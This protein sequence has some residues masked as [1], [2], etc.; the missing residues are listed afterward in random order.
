MPQRTPRRLEERN[1]GEPEG[2]TLQWHTNGLR[3]TRRFVGQ[4]EMLQSIKNGCPLVERALPFS[5][6]RLTKG[7]RNINASKFFAVRNPAQ[8]GMESVVVVDPSP[9]VVRTSVTAVPAHHSNFDINV[10]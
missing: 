8:I 7:I 6:P 1:F 10:H 9:D 2:I 5:R 4:T 3:T